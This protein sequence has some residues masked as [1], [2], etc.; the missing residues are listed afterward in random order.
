YRIG[1]CQSGSWKKPQDKLKF[2][3]RFASGNDYVVAYC[4]SNE[5]VISGSCGTDLSAAIDTQGINPSLNGYACGDF[6]NTAKV[7][8]GALCL[9]N[10]F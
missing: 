3:W 1:N 10:G 5:K 6:G 8:A 2:N 7:F 9:M 4:S